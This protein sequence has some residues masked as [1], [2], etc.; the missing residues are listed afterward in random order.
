MENKVKAKVSDPNLKISQDKEY[1]VL[2]YDP[3]K[4]KV[5]VLDDNKQV[6]WVDLSLFLNF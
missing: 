3:N 6:V 2:D 4:N 1:D 5:K